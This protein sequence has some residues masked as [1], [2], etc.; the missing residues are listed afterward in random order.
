MVKNLIAE[1]IATMLSS[2]KA[3]QIDDVS[4]DGEI[5]FKDNKRMIVKVTDLSY[6]DGNVDE[7]EKKCKTRGIG[8]FHNII[9]PAHFKRLRGI[10]IDS[11]YSARSLETLETPA[12]D[13]FA[14]SRLSTSKFTFYEFVS[15]I[16]AL[17]ESS[18]KEK[19][20]LDFFI[21]QKSIDSIMSLFESDDLLYLP[22]DAADSINGKNFPY[23]VLKIKEMAGFVR[24]IKKDKKFGEFSTEDII[25]A[26]MKK[27]KLDEHLKLF[28]SELLKSSGQQFEMIKMY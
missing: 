9:L 22:Y 7:Y 26:L 15:S 8:E 2:E 19:S 4:P 17:R 23:L 21:D 16:E 18:P 14:T 28:H 5:T 12:F 6:E 25:R 13:Y 24:E 27:M 3:Y 20:V 1:K 11:C 10:N